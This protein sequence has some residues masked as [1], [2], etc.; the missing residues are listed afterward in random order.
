MK[1]F[2][3][4]STRFVPDCCITKRTTRNSQLLHISKYIQNLHRTKNL[5]IQS[6]LILTAASARLHETYTYVPT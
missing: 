5:L 1:L 4:K 3:D 6:N 2:I